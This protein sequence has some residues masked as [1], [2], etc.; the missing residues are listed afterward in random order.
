ML[1]NAPAPHFHSGDSESAL[2]DI[3]RWRTI[4]HLTRNLSSNPE[5]GHAMDWKTANE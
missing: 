1:V 3:Y 5:K 2:S 4:G